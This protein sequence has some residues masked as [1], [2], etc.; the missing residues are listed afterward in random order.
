VLGKY[1][2]TGQTL[3]EKVFSL[4]FEIRLQISKVLRTVAV[5]AAAISAFVGQAV[6]QLEH[7]Q[8]TGA[9]LSA[10][11]CSCAHSHSVFGAGF[12]GDGQGP[13]ED[14]RPDDGH[15]SQNCQICLLYVMQASAP[16]RA[17]AVQVVP[18]EY[19]QALPGA[20]QRIEQWGPA[21]AAR[22]PPCC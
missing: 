8:P 20:G 14:E 10:R 2:Q 12:S 1:A 16:A 15:D 13:V 17:V 22:G 5:A 19:R 4:M 9:E 3:L 6:H 21:T 7:M 18:F 11:R